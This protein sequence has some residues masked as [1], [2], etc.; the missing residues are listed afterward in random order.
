MLWKMVGVMI[1]IGAYGLWVAWAPR[2]EDPECVAVMMVA[3]GSVLLSLVAFSLGMLSVRNEVSSGTADA[4]VMT[5]VSRRKLIISKLAGSAEFMVIVALLLPMYCFTG[6]SGG[7]TSEVAAYVHGGWLRWLVL[8]ESWSFDRLPLDAVWGVLAFASD[9]T[10]Y[11]LFAACGVWAAVSRR[12][13]A[14]QWLKGLSL[15]ALMLLFWFIAERAGT[16]LTWYLTPPNYNVQGNSIGLLQDITEFFTGLPFR[17]NPT[18]LMVLLVAISMG[19]RLL[20]AWGLVL[21]SIRHFDRIA[22]D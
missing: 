14:I 7:D 3:V 4:L 6:I 16:E 19:L 1:V 21:R 18:W 17:H 5:P 13:V 9:S 10:W 15:C 2:S 8:S 22:T 12:H 11:L 20:V